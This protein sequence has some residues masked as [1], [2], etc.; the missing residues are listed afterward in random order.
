M[1]ALTAA[2]MPVVLLPKVLTAVTMTRKTSEAIRP[3]S[4]A[5]A[6]L[7]SFQNRLR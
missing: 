5:V 2:M 7:S 3:Y 4:M 6:P 1:A